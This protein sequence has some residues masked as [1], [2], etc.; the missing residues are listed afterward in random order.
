MA[1]SVPVI[2]EV[3]PT[4]GQPPEVYTAISCETVA[5]L[6]TCHRASVPVVHGTVLSLEDSVLAFPLI[7]KATPFQTKR[8]LHNPFRGIKPLQKARRFPD[9]RLPLAFF[10]A[11][12]LRVFYQ[13]E[14]VEL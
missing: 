12:F 5:S 14:F 8:T 10:T 13:L 2:L 11:R 6:G 1:G 7:L 4:L 3:S 9:S